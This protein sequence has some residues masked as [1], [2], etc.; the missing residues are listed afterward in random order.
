M[1]SYKKLV[2]TAADVRC[3][4]YISDSRE[5]RSISCEGFDR[6]S[7]IQTRFKNLALRERHMGC[8]CVANYE[9]CPLYK[10]T[11]E[12]KYREDGA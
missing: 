5:A 7:T 4:F 9:G 11:F 1:G 8:C 2:W 6:D 3:P 10:S 12:S